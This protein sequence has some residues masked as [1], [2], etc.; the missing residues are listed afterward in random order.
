MKEKVFI[1]DANVLLHDPEAI[2][3]F[4]RH[5]VAIPVTVLEELDKLKRTPGELGKNARAAIRELAALKNMGEGNLHTGVKLENTTVI[6]ILM[7]MKTDYSKALA[8]TISDNKILMAA[9][10]LLEQGQRVVFVSKDF[11]ARV[12]AEAIGL[13]TEDYQNFKFSYDSL[14]KGLQHLEI[15]K[16]LIDHFYKDTHILL[17]NLTHRPNEYFVLTSPEHSSAVARY[18][19]AKEQLTPLLKTPNLWGVKSRNVEQKCVIDAL[20]RDDI[21][22][23]TVLGPAGTGKTL[24][25][26]ACG[27][28]KVFDEGVYSKILVSRPIV[29]LG[30][31]IG[32]LPGTKEEKLTSWMQPIFD[33]LELLCASMNGEPSETLTWVLDSKKIEMEAVTYIRGRSLPKMYIIIDEAQNLTPH[34]VK[35]IIS[36]AGDGTK[37]VLTGDPTQ[38]DNPY[39]DKDSNGLVYTVGRFGSSKIHANVYLEK[40]ERSELAA[41][42]T[43]LL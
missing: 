42:A 39:L 34:E 38:I 3:K 20:L 26:L 5:E 31:D 35:T 1:L 13:E 2:F 6:R 43:E 24:L 23:V 21:K 14:S 28:R 17:P 29:P 9:Y 19:S 30:R 25:A 32:Y 7:E 11:A 16:S 37:V 18:D 33:N 27:L 10:L 40:T 22:L 4:P 15:D 41:Q 8:L 12:K 36:R